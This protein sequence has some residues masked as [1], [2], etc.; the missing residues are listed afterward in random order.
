MLQYRLEAAWKAWNRPETNRFH[1]FRQTMTQKR[2]KFSIWNVWWRQTFQK[3]ISNLQTRKFW[4]P[5]TRLVFKLP[6]TGSVLDFLSVLPDIELKNFSLFVP[7]KNY[8]CEK[9]KFWHFG[10]CF[11]R[12]DRGEVVPFQVDRCVPL[13]LITPKRFLILRIENTNQLPSPQA[14]KDEEATVRLACR[15]SEIISYLEIYG[16]SKTFWHHHWL[17]R[18]HK[19]LQTARLREILVAFRGN[20]VRCS[21]EIS[22][23]PQTSSSTS[24][25]KQKRIS[26][27]GKLHLAISI[28]EAQILHI[29]RFQWGTYPTIGILAEV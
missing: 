4:D 15:R 23:W 1:L 27:S 16:I 21:Y 17:V 3:T 8:V 10:C 29:F 14:T 12:D 28:P 19:L 7:S 11:F 24:G 13:H 20:G 6:R 2:V 5:G 9:I 26:A 25:M 18:G 22:E